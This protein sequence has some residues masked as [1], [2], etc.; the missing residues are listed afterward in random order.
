MSK[1]SWYCKNGYAKV[2]DTLEFSK[3]NSV[4]GKP[5]ERATII[6][7]IPISNDNLRVTLLFDDKTRCCSDKIWDDRIV[8][9]KE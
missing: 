2:G 1:E 7:F 3:F 5:D 4:S 9:E 6:G 8:N